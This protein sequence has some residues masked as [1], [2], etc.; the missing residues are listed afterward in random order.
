MKPASY[1]HFKVIIAIVFTMLCY[2][3]EAQF[4]VSGKITNAGQGNALPGAHIRL[5][6]SFKAVYSDAEGKYEL[7]NIAAGEI[8]LKYT[9]IGYENKSLSF[10][11]SS[12][13]IINVSIVESI[14]MADE[15]II[16]STRATDKSAMAYSTVTLEEI[17]QQNFGQDLPYLLNTTPSVVTTSDAGAGVGYTGIRIRGS[18]ATRINVTINGIPLND[19]ESQGVFWVDLPD[20]AS[21]VENIQIQ[22]GV[23]TSTNGAGAF[24]GSIN[25]QTLTLKQNP[26]GIISNA[27]GSFNT[28]KHTAEFGSGLINNNFSFD[29]RLSKITSDGYIDRASSDLKSLFLSGGYYGKNNILK[30]NVISGIEETY[31]AW[32]GVPEDSLEKNRSFNSAG[33]YYDND[34][35]INYY[36]RE[37]DNYQQDHYQ[38]IWANNIT[39]NLNFQTALHYTYG[40]G[41]YEQYRQNDRF[42]RYQLPNVVIGNDTITRSDLIRRRWLDNHF[43]GITYSLNYI[44][45]NKLNLIIGGAANR[46]DGDH[47]GEVI[48]ARISSAGIRHRYYDNNGLKDDFNIFGKAIYSLSNN[49]SLFADLQYR[50]VSYSFLGFDN[51]LSNLQ[52]EAQLNFINPKA[53]IT[54]DLNSNNRIYASYSVGNKEPSRKDYTESTP[55]S[56]PKPENLQDL[57]AG[58]KYS[59]RKISAGVN[60][61]YMYYIDQLV[62]T[63]EINDVGAYTRTNVDKSYRTGVELEAVIQL[64]N[65]ISWQANLT[66]GKSSILT[67]NEFADSLSASYGWEDN[68]VVNVHENK[69]IAFSPEIIGSSVISFNIVKP[70]TISLIS[71]YVGEQFLDNT[72]NENRK[73]DAYL[74]NDIRINFSQKLWKFKA[75]EAGF[76]INNVFDEL[77]SSNGYT[78]SYFV[79]NKLVTENFYYPQAGRNF[80]GMLTLK[81]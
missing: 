19:A 12:D 53:G 26:Y 28:L 71:K 80:M 36:D 8:T 41:Y 62:L 45:S 77:Y 76:L 10:Y 51:D 79:G 23:G 18:D 44:P 11:L 49:F 58:Y 3:V 29:G 34:G 38:L 13:T 43:Y 20:L 78:Y 54:Y 66:L 57:E 63:G 59:G 6:N 9:H 24:G 52:Q 33:L 14:V 37:V 65:I 48:W 4:S 16:S 50:S 81:F 56:R 22:R 15:V 75:V 31:Q 5:E 1:I 7:K 47:F 21:S 35:N 72:A 69:P 27:A 61:Y 39:N 64:L 60:Y 25:V 70:L 67:F 73:L 30:L 17:E 42:S 74:V 46:Y 68:V 32:Y 40:R 55:L 2:P